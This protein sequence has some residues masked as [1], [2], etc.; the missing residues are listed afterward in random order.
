LQYHRPFPALHYNNWTHY[1]TLQFY[2]YITCSSMHSPYT[3]KFKLVLF[4]YHEYGSKKLNVYFTHGFFLTCTQKSRYIYKS[5]IA[6]FTRH[7]AFPPNPTP[8]IINKT[9]PLYL[10]GE[11]ASLLVVTNTHPPLSPSAQISSNMFQFCP[12]IL[13]YL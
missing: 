1:L 7:T 13:A 3:S 4:R 9:T 12:E 8:C 5:F 2:Q 10:L 6:I 11:Q